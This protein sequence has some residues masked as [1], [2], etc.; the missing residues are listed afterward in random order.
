VFAT[1]AQATALSSVAPHGAQE[2]SGQSTGIPPF[3][4]SWKA[5]GQLR[6]KSGAPE[7][8]FWGTE[9]ALKAGPPAGASWVS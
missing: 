8:C 7:L 4:R 5:K 6:R 2:F 3:L 9:K 1:D